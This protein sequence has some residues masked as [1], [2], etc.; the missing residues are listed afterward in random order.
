VRLDYGKE[1]LLLQVHQLR[2]HIRLFVIIAF[3]LGE[4]R[5]VPQSSFSWPALI[6]SHSSAGLIPLSRSWERRWG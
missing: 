1:R 2:C 5:T 6:S 4:R 3:G